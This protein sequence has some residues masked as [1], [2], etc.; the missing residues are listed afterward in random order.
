MSRWLAMGDCR[1]TTGCAVETALL[2]AEGVIRLVKIATTWRRYH[3]W[4]VVATNLV[5]DALDH[6]GVAAAERILRRRVCETSGRQ[7]RDV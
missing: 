4:L 2:L 7:G 1:Y 6:A 5:V 3:R